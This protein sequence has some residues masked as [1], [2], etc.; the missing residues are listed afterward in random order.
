M[1]WFIIALAA[2]AL[3][4]GVGL[5]ASGT[6]GEVRLSRDP[7]AAALC[8]EGTA[9]MHAL[10]LRAAID[11]LGRSLDADPSLAEAAISLAWA[12]MRLGERQ[13]MKRELVRADSLTSLLAND[14]RRL[15][16]QLRLS[17]FPTSRF[18]AMYDSV[19]DI[20]KVR[21]PDN[22]YVLEAGAVRIAQTQDDNL[23]AEAWQRIIERN[24]NY[25]NAYNM[26][27]YHEM[28]RGNFDLAIE[29]MQK[30]AFLSPELANPHDSLG[31]VYMVL[32]RYEDAESQYHAAVKLQPDFYFSIINLGRIYLARGEIRRGLEILE[33]LRTHV[34]GSD[35]EVTV[36]RAVIAAYRRSG[37]DDELATATARF[38][39]RYPEQDITPILRAIRL[40]HAGR[41]AEGKAIMD[42]SL[43]VR[44]TEAVYV[45]Y[46]KARQEL[47]GTAHMVEAMMAD[48][49]G[50]G[51]RAAAAW[52][53]AL[54][55]ISSVASHEDIFFVKH[56]LAASLR[57]TKRPREAASIL[58]SVV[59]I[60]PRLP[61]VLLLKAQCHLDVAE[62]ESAAATLAQLEAALAKADRDLPILAEAAALRSRLGGGAP[63]P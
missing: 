1:K 43:T 52:S 51:E 3:L 27:G 13:N 31:D 30:Y 44:R 5:V 16:A 45:R 61:E 33:A 49:D 42:S 39:D 14:Q 25:A 18:V 63:V 59:R 12:Y 6:Q 41:A 50:D 57:A 55:L 56:R 58:D 7:E 54:D 10:R 37:L 47:E 24:P 22:I 9:D 60:N 19:Y 46:E 4:V 32:G 17:A 28:K 26:L 36:D 62:F 35:L 40:A 8:E 15:V 23:T 2:A 53:K 20:L 29:Y 38:I 48:L 34:A 21:I 11:K